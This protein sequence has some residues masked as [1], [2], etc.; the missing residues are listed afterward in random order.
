MHSALIYLNGAAGSRRGSFG[1]FCDREKCRGSFQEIG[2]P[3]NPVDQP[4][5]E[6]VHIIRLNVSGQ[7]IETNEQTF[8]RFPNS[9]LGDTTK[10]KLLWNH[11][12]KEYFIERHRPSFEAVLQ[13]YQTGYLRRPTEVPLDI[14]LE[15][16]E[17]HEFEPQ[18][19]DGFKETEGLILKQSLPMPRDKTKRFFW[20]LFED[21]DSSLGARIIGLISIT[22]TALSVTIVCMETLPDYKQRFCRNITYNDSGRVR[23]MHVPNYNDIHVYCE[24]FCVL[25]FTM[26][27]AIRLLSCPSHIRFAFIT[28]FTNVLEL[29]TL[30]PY[31]ILLIVTLITNSCY[32]SQRNSVILV[33]RSLRV[34]RIFRLTKHSTFLEIFARAIHKCLRELRL[35]LFITLVGC[36]VLAVFVV[37]AEE[38]EGSEIKTVAEGIWW[39]IATMTTVGYGDVYPVGKW[40]KLVGCVCFIMGCLIVALPTPIIVSNF[41]HFYKSQRPSHFIR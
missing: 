14:F 4:P 15:E 27:Y 39:A 19:L 1:Y 26:E 30:I 17:W 40:G 11:R 38:G 25:W 18:I 2:T 21:I 23:H 28:R 33:L 16:L 7:I 5:G 32:I 24:L 20:R 36:V 12:R 31:Y 8:S 41:N 10:R 37:V 3:T 22:A 34:I 9:R 29:V 13:F 35:F 6:P